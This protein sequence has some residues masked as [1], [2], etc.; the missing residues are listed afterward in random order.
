MQQLIESGRIVDVMLVFVVL[1]IVVLVTYRARTG[2]GIPP[3]PLLLNIGAGGSL[4][5]A[6]GASLKGFG[7]QVVAGLLIAALVFHVA[8]LRQRWSQSTDT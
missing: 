8:D 3:L 6:L 7:W 2:H 1:E 4:M 5:L